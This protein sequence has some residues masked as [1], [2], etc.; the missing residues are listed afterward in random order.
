MLK[1]GHEIHKNVNVSGNY[2]DNIPHSLALTSQD[3]KLPCLNEI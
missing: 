3:L 2:D 1:A